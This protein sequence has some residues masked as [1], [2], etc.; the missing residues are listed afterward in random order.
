MLTTQD[1]DL[2]IF[3]VNGG[4]FLSSLLEC[5]RCI[6]QLLRRYLKNMFWRDVLLLAMRRCA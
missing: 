3:K 6:G 4:Y 1:V 5:R 2:P